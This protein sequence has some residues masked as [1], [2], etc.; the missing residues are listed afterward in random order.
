MARME[1]ERPV[2]DDPRYGGTVSL[3]YGGEMDRGMNALV[4]FSYES[5]QHQAF[6]NQM[7]LI[8]YDE[9]LEPAPYLAASWEVAPDTSAV[10][11]HL[12]DDVF[13]HDGVPTT[14]WDVAFT[15]ER[16]TDPRT[17]F[18]N[19]TYFDH[20]V[21]GSAGVEVRDS[22]TVT[23]RLARPHAEF[24]DPWRTF[25]IMPRHL[26]EDVPPDRLQDHPFG[27][28]CP[29]GNGPFV[30]VSHR[31]QESWTFRANPAFPEGLGGRPFVDRYVYRVVPEPTPRLTEIL[32]GRA[33]V[34]VSVEPFQARQI[35]EAE[36][37]EL[38]NFVFRDYVF[39]VWNSR[40]AQ[41]ADPRVRR[42]LT[43][44]TNRAAIIEALA[45]GYG[46]V[47]N[48]TVPPFH[49]SYDPAMEG[50]LPY[51]PEEARAL[52][53][54]GGWTD[55]DGDGVRESADGT[56]LRIGLKYNQGNSLRR[57][58]A[59]LMQSQL[60]QVGV[61]IVPEVVE[62]TT[63][64]NELGDRDRD[65]DGVVM[66]FVND[67]K[68]DDRDIFHSERVDGPYAWS[69]TRNPELDALMDTL[70]LITDRNEAIGLWRR[71]QRLLVEEQPFTFFYFRDRLDA[72]G[73]RLR[74]AR[75]DI[76]GEW[77]NIRDWWIDPER[78]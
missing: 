60:A 18:P 76:R 50:L 13:W 42:A 58:I 39:V 10:T 70:P 41:L 55:R 29:V 31:H 2:P 15:Y 63:L 52:L 44:G 49:W 51:D 27:T 30:F 21:P 37:V 16:A 61:E 20:Y 19:V 69:G 73:G 46:R 59:E 32:T 68:L 75:M 17:A 54:E 62:Y 4:S 5:L 57:G 64:Q 66:G 72:V 11:F 25:P 40:R 78:R 3:V 38:R 22:L 35:L 9:A 43:V 65:F 77:V 71:Y 53:A 56:R 26:L 34:Y 7:T 12:R 14:A 24:M 1:G 67:F 45:E 28:Q 47:A 33:D 74:N 48:S 36:D 8:R 23:I 6:V